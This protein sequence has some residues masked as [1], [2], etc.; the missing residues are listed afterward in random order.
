MVRR[1][2]GQIIAELKDL[3]VTALITAEKLKTEQTMGN[4]GI[5]EFVVDG[6]IELELVQGQ[7]QFLRRM[8]VIKI[9]GADFRSGIVEF[10]ITNHGLIV[11]PKIPAENLFAQTDF[12]LRKTFGINK[13]DDI[14]GG[15]IPQGHIMLLSGNTGTGKTHFS[16]NFL[17][18]GIRDGDNAVFVSL[19]EPLDQIKKT[20]LEMGLNFA[21]YEKERKIISITTSLIDISNDKLLYEIL[22]AVEKVHAKRVVIDAISS[23]NS[24]TMS[25]EQVRQFLIQL[26]CFFKANGITCIMNHLAPTNFGAERGQ[27]LS[28]ASSEAR[29]SS[30]TDGIMMLLYVERGQKIKKL[31]N[32][33]KLRGSWHSKDIINYEIT[34]DGIVI[35]DKYEE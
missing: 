7:Q 11:Y 35:G 3:E 32:V 12:T 17:M 14:L 29:L 19:E 1:T 13:L 24:S 6:V 33:L 25:Y 10:E 34:N 27:L 23:L 30:I 21:P 8:F 2:I 22:S 16:L 20:S 18:Q 28:G 31:L 15:G 5:E 9:R 4:Y 26:A